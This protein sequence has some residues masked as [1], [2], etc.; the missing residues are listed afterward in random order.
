V[1]VLVVVSLVA[2]LT[3]AVGYQFWHNRTSFKFNIKRDIRRFFEGDIKRASE[4]ANGEVEMSVLDDNGHN[5][6]VSSILE[7]GYV[8]AIR[9]P[10]DPNLELSFGGTFGERIG[11]G[12]YG[13]VYSGEV[14]L[15]SGVMEKVAVKTSAREAGWEAT[16]SLLDEILIMTFIGGHPN[17]VQLLGANTS[18]LKSKRKRLTQKNVG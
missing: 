4:T 10:Y 14:Q 15:Q 7:Q 12:A 9:A 3:T 18:S 13:E 6:V 2:I 1:S 8:V 11:G 17:I 16:K 5:Y